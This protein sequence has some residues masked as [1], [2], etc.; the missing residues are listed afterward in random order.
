MATSSFWSSVARRRSAASLL[1]SRILRR[2]REA[3]LTTTTTTTRNEIVGSGPRWRR[4]RAY[5]A[6][7][8]DVAGSRSR[9]VPRD[10]W[11]DGE[12]RGA[13]FNHPSSFLKRAVASSPS[14]QTEQNEP[15][16][17]RDLRD[18]FMNANS[19][20]YLEEIERRFKEDGDKGMDQSWSN[21]L[22][23]LDNNSIFSIL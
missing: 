5:R 11:R 20:A 2:G 7:P 23:N 9:R 16:P 15:T 3:P 22:K 10:G 19:V 17:M 13:M 14:T 12:R 8:N 18:E 6:A 21:L 4:H 1:V